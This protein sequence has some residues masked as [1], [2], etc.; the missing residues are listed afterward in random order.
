MPVAARFHAIRD[1][2]L[3]AVDWRFAEP[4]RL[5]FIK[6][7]AV[8]PDRAMVEIEAPLRVAGDASAITLKGSSGAGW[9]PI[10]EAGKAELYIDRATY[11]GPPLRA[12]DRVKALSR[13][14]EPWFEVASVDDRTQGRL[15]AKLNNK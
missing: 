12:G 1:R 11:A 13:P 10:I 8:D 9:A 7:G 2:V 15:I 14:G 6:G 3:A 5:S 4:V